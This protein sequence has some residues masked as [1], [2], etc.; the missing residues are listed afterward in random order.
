MRRSRAPGWTSL[1]GPLSRTESAAVLGSAGVTAAVVG[2]RTARRSGPVRGG[3]MAVVAAD[4][5]G[6][7]VTFQLRPTRRKYGAS[8]LRSRLTF[9]LV[10][11]QPFLL[12]AL[13]LGSWQRAAL[14]YGAAVGSTAAL[15][16][17]PAGEPAR[18]RLATA[19]AATLSVA[20]VASDTSTQRWFGPVYL[21]KVVGG[22][23]GIPPR[24]RTP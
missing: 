10:H 21:I 8:S 20:D 12:P 11:V 18:R 16:L 7:L 3:L 15:E 13:G 23:G 24:G 19:V 2:V 14:R 5:A 1:V 22:H 9:V 17:V 6:G 4:L